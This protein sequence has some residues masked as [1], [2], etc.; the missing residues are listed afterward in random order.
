VRYAWVGLG[1]E[2]RESLD[3]GEVDEKARRLGRVMIFD[4]HHVRIFRVRDVC[5]H[6]YL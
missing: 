3:V 5:M 2:W 4:W 6:V 1:R